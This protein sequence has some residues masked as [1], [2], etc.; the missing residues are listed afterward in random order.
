[1][2]AGAFEGT[3]PEDPKLLDFHDSGNNRIAKRSTGIDSVAEARG[4]G[5]THTSK[6]A[7]TKG[8]TV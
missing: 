5:W 7:W 4:L 3:G 2:N 8:Y 6:D 1:M